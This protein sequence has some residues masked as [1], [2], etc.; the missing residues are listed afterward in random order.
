[1]FKD[2]ASVAIDGRLRFLVVK[3]SRSEQAIKGDSP[4]KGETERMDTMSAQPLEKSLR[5][6]RF[7]SDS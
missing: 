5:Y 2:Q 1:M 4:A 6:A 3:K 7:E